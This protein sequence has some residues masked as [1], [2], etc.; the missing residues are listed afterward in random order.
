MVSA[1]DLS[2]KLDRLHAQMKEYAPA[3]KILPVALDEW[4]VNLPKDPPEGASAKPP[5]GVKDAK[6]IGLY[7]TVLSLRDAVDEGAVYNLMQRRPQDFG[8]STR[9]IVYAYMLGLIG[10]G[11]DRVVASPSALSVELFATRDRC[12]SLETA[13][14]GPTFDVAPARGYLG[15]KNAN[16]LD[17]SARLH[18]DGKTLAIFVVNR[19]IEK[20]IP[21]IVRIL[22]AIA[23]KTAELALISNANLLE[24]NTFAEPERVKI[25]RSRVSV[26]NGEVR[27]TF[28]AHSISR[29]TIRLT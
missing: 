20:E 3:G 1:E 9:T 24:W 14:E 7:G 19:D 28:P 26:E 13:V 5:Q 8:L 12:E 16:L 4:A 23:G 25:A 22:G 29:L 17:V 15:A 6:Q 2:G 21:G 10:I 27:Y 18:S 11:R